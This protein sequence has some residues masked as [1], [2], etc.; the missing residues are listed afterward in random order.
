[1]GLGKFYK[2]LDVYASLSISLV[3]MY[4]VDPLKRAS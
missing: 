4:S 3:A 2:I 1:M